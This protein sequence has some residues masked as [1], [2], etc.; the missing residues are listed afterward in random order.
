MADAASPA[1]TSTDGKPALDEVM[2]AMD[3]V[4]TLRHA[5]RL[6]ERELSADE[7]DRQMKERL[8]QIYA[9]Q[10]IEVTDAVLEEG[11]KALR[12]ERFAYSPAKPG[13]GRS[14]AMLWIT[15]GRWGKW[16]GIALIAIA[17]L[18]AGYWYGVHLPEERRIAG[19]ARELA[20]TLP[21]ALAA[22]RERILAI[23]RV[24]RA[25]AAAEQWF[26]EGAAAVKAGDAKEA[27]VKLVEMQALR[28]L[29]ETAYVV[30]VVSRPGERS[31]VFRI[32]DA[33]SSARNYYLI[34]EAVDSAGQRVPVRITS[35]EDNR[36]DTVSTWG[37][38]VDAAT[39]NR[40]AADKQDDGIIQN[41]RV[42]EK[43]PGSLAPE[44][45]VPVTGAILNW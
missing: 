25:K 38:R 44:Y 17:V 32:P 11:V 9:T 23:A 26:A 41:N 27:R 7:R 8:R 40:I 5:E 24:D 35:E 21:R 20:E 29:L 4:D 2:L 36:T 15:R 10:G 14:L 28:K 31:G 18:G 42:G 39:Y 6:V 1:A 22:E 3:V 34:V 16:A 43:T 30:R 45:A 37:V 12:E 13:L 19:N 33:N